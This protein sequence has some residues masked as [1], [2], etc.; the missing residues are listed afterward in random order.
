MSEIKV[1][2][3][4]RVTAPHMT[5]DHAGQIGIIDRNDGMKCMPWYVR[6]DDGEEEPFDTYE[7][8]P[9]TVTVVEADECDTDEPESIDYLVFV[10]E[11]HEYPPGS[12]GSYEAAFGAAEEA[13]N[14]GLGNASV[15]KLVAEFEPA[16]VVTTKTY[17]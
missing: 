5:T 7:L 9:I 11:T 3:A 12:Y 2:D 1:G 6:F 4:V 13:A 16:I 10:G 17:A 14:K 15:Y 8:E